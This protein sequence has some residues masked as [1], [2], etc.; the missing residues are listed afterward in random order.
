MTNCETLCYNRGCGK[1][2]NPRDN[3]PDSEACKYHPGAPFFHETYKGWTCC[4]KKSSDF[5]EFLNT[6][7]CARGPHSREKPIEPENITGKIDD[8]SLEE[9]LKELNGSSSGQT[10]HRSPEP[11]VKETRPDF[12]ESSLILLKPSRAASLKPITV[13]TTNTNATEGQTEI[14]ENE[15]CKNGGCKET[16]SSSTLKPECKYHPGVPV[17]HEGMKFWS[18]CQRRTTDFQ[19][20]L[21]QEGCMLGEHKWKKDDEGSA[22]VECRYDWHQTAT[23]VTVAV[24]AKKYD[25]DI[26]KVEIHPIRLK[27]H[28]YFP[29]QAGAFDLDLELGGIINVQETTASMAGTKVEIKMKKA[30]PGSWAKL[31]IPREVKL[32]VKEQQKVAQDNENEKI[33]ALDLDDLD[34]T[35][36]RAVLSNE[37]SGG[38]S[39]AEIR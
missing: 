28:I 30:E 11:T 35:P 39:G 29:E 27:T 25:P 17:F 36:Q 18:C 15:P 16:Y 1:Q 5:T 10:K 2:Y 7:G 9:Q 13:T 3:P 22:K 33:D 26:S 23:H 31:F 19:S 6:P 32:V 4:N 34:L 38:R 12:D 14:P 21:N 37:A 8:R 20:F 24:Y